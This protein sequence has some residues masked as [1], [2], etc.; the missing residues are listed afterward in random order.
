M[1][2]SLGCGNR[3]P[4]RIREQAASDKLVASAISLSVKVSS[5]GVILRLNQASFRWPGCSRAQ[6]RFRRCPSLIA[7]PRTRFKGDLPPLSRLR[8]RARRS[9]TP[10]CGVAAHATLS[11]VTFPENFKNGATLDC[12]REGR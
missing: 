3:W 9:H 5:F 12:G 10:P 6:L 11:G 4:A 2:Q 1:S 7:S 8:V